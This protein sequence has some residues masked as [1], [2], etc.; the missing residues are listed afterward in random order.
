M[1]RFFIALAL[2][3]SLASTQAMAQALPC[4]AYPNTL[5]NGTLADANQV[6]ANFNTIR[7]CVNALAPLGVPVV[8]SSSKI[9]AGLATSG[10]TITVSADSITV[11]TALNGTSYTLTS[12]SQSFNGAT[13]G[14]GGMDTGSLPTS[15]WVA[16]YAIYNPTAPAISILGTNCATSCP[17]IYSGGA[18][19]A[20]YTASAILA[21]LPTNATPAIIGGTYIKGKKAFVGGTTALSTASTHASPTSLSLTTSVPPNAISVGGYLTQTCGTTPGG[22]SNTGTVSS[23]STGGGALGIFV[24]GCA[25]TSGSN[26]IVNFAEVALPTAQTVWYTN[27]VQGTGSP[28]FAINVNNY[29]IP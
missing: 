7:N 12:Y 9:S 6:M 5:T 19:P 4:A 14:A 8:G 25:S 22:A 20:G 23:D 28:V 1:R 16:L 3:L 27:S 24:M 18:L 15:G 29:T 13:V 11:G 10:T 17:T 21:V 2:L 26:G